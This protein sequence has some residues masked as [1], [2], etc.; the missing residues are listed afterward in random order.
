MFPGMG[1]GY[2][3]GYGYRIDHTMLLLIPAIFLTLYAHY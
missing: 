3:Y 2:G 1:Y